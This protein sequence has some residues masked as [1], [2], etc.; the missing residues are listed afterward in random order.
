MKE[1]K[2]AYSIA[3]T[4]IAGST[5]KKTSIINSDVD[6]IL[7]VNENEP[8]FNDV[9][10]KWKLIVGSSSELDIERIRKG[11]HSIQF[12]INGIQIDL[13]PAQNLIDTD[14]NWSR[15]KCKRIRRRQRNRTLK[16]ISED[17]IRN[18]YIYTVHCLLE[19]LGNFS[20]N[21]KD[22]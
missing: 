17:P 12:T 18:N 21:K 16:A 6:G 7:Y 10:W 15:Q 20:D 3:R 8:P 14:P 22:S 9:L 11:R 4:I 13:L 2:G 5:G 19:L 1:G